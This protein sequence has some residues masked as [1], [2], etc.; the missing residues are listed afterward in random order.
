[1]PEGLTLAHHSDPLLK[2][3]NLQEEVHPQFT[4]NLCTYFGESGASRC[5]EVLPV[6]V[7]PCDLKLLASYTHT[8]SIP[9]PSV[10]S[11]TQEGNGKRQA[12]TLAVLG[13]SLASFT[14][15]CSIWQEVKDEHEDS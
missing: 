12:T 10:R 14:S 7:R 3:P 2:L 4:V 9:S 8:V 1:M 5:S 13:S 11:G 15:S 6:T